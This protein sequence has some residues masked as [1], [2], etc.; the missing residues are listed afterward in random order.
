[1]HKVNNYYKIIIIEQ[2]EWEFSSTKPK[3]KV[4]DIKYFKKFESKGKIK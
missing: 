3:W 1:M 4:I 2:Q